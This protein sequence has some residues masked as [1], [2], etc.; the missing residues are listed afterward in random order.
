MAS[1][2]GSGKSHPA[3]SVSSYYRP[4]PY[5]YQN[6]YYLP[7]RSAWSR[8]PPP[9][10]KKSNENK[11]WKIGSAVLVVSGLI[12]LV[13]VLAI[14]GLALWMGAMRSDIK[15]SSIGFS[16]SL[17]IAR[18][19]KYNP[20]LKLNTSMVFREMERKYKNIFELLFRRSVLGSCFKQT[21]IDR[22]ENGTLKV[23]F[24]LYLDRRKIPRSITN[25]EDTIQ[26][27]I[28]KETYSTTSLFKDMELD[29]TSISIRRINAESST[30]R[31]QK[32][33]I[34]QQRNTMI[35]KNGLLRPNKTS[36]LL[37]TQIQKSK[38]SKI[39]PNEADIDFTN[40]PTIQGSYQ[41]TKL[42]LTNDAQKNNIKINTNRNFT[43]TT[44][45]TTTARSNLSINET[46][47]KDNNKS[48]DDKIE[49][50]TASTTILP[51]KKISTS[52]T[53][54][55]TTTIKRNDEFEKFSH[56]SFEESPWRPII[57]NYSHTE[58]IFS[59]QNST[60][61]SSIVSQTNLPENI[62]QKN[63]GNFEYGI[64]ETTEKINDDKILSTTNLSLDDDL[65]FNYATISIE[66]DFPHDRIVPEEMINFRPNGKFKNKIPSIDDAS[67]FDIDRHPDIEISGHLPEETFD[68][69]LKTFPG[70]SKTPETPKNA[71]ND[72][73]KRDKPVE[74]TQTVLDEIKNKNIDA[75]DE[76][77]MSKIFDKPEEL[78][79]SG[80][81]I[82]E[83]VLEHEIDIESRN[84]FSDI[85]AI[86][87][88]DEKIKNDKNI[89]QQIVS[90]FYTS[91]RTPE[92]NGFIKPS[93]ID[94]PGTLKPFKHTIPVDKISSNTDPLSLI[95]H[96][97]EQAVTKN[98]GDIIENKDDLILPDFHDKTFDTKENHD[99]KKII[100]TAMNPLDLKLHESSTEN[101]NNLTLI[102]DNG[103]SSKPINN[104]SAIESTSP[105]INST[106]VEVVTV[107]H[108]P[109]LFED[110]SSMWK[111]G[112]ESTT[113]A[114]IKT[115]ND[116]LKAN[117]VKSIVTLAPTKSNSGVNRPIRP[118]PV[119]ENDKVTR[120]LIG[121]TKTNDNHHLI[122]GGT[123]LQS[124]FGS[125]DLVKP[126]LNQQNHHHDDDNKNIKSIVEVVTSISTKVSTKTKSNSNILS[127]YNVTNSTS[128]PQVDFQHTKLINDENLQQENTKQL[129]NFEQINP[130]VNN[131]QL[132]YEKLKKFA[133]IR[134]DN[135][136]SLP[137]NKN[138]TK[139]IPLK[140]ENDDD[141]R[142]INI[143]FDKI[144]E[145][146]NV[147]TGNKTIKAFNDNENSSLSRD[148][149]EI[150][151]KTLH[152]VD[153][154]KTTTK[155]IPTTTTT[156]ATECLTGFLCN[157]GKCLPATGR[158]NMLG[159]CLNSEDEA[160]CTCADFLKTQLLVHKICDGILDCWDYSDEENCDWCTK[161]QFVCGNSQ[162]CVDQGKVCDGTWDCP[163]GEDE[164]KCAALIEDDKNHDNKTFDNLNDRI[165]NK[166]YDGKN[167][168]SKIDDNLNKKIINTN[169]KL[170]F[171]T[172]TTLKI[173]SDDVDE[174]DNS[175]M[176]YLDKNVKV[177]GRE[178]S[179]S[180]KNKLMGSNSF[181]AS[182]KVGHIIENN[183]KHVKEV[184]GYS[185][186]GFLSVRKNGKW[187]KLCLNGME[188]LM[189]ERRALWTIEDLGRAVCKAI[190]YQ[191][192]ENVEKITDD[193]HD[194]NKIYY[195]LFFNDKTTDKTSLTF[196]LSTCP[197]REVLRVKC[198]NLECGIRTQT[199]SQARIVGGD[200]STAGSWPWQ[201]AL[202]KE[203]DY[204]CGG[205]LINNKWILSAAH[206]F[207]RTQNEYWVA[208]IG[209][210][211]R[212][213][214][215][216]PHEQIITLDYVALHPD[217]IDNGF[218]NDVALL[219]LEKS[220][221]FSDYVRPICLPDAEPK[222][223]TKCTVTGWGQLFEVGRIFPDTLQEVELPLISTEEC[224]R[225]T[226]FLPLYRITAGMLCAGLKDG[227]RDACMG[228]SGG[229]LVCRGPD[230][231]YTLHGITS[232]G[233]G[234]A[235]PGRPGVYTKVHH[236][237]SWIDKTMLDTDVPSIVPV[238]KGHRCPLGEC[239]PKSRVCNG[240]LEC[241]DGSDERNCMPNL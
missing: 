50:S 193:R 204:Q 119:I 151:T 25:V 220:V 84:K 235:R 60:T 126:L 108:K 182:S 219:R 8:V 121:N 191:D 215:P 154:I 206:C 137:E 33:N 113:E 43:T 56:P 9:S 241:S 199:T 231:R 87:N 136:S 180:T 184:N 141:D 79:I 49:T 201:V 173:I 146:A 129:R 142:K 169:D 233:Y 62:N 205:A 195:S 149:I 40:I 55:S 221:V 122:E 200:S 133:E 222:S 102:I 81:G 95:N 17:R 212:G 92:L 167:I 72:Y 41:A 131:E 73:G 114:G 177:V 93:I 11:T 153:D 185:D 159:E 178:I 26:D 10:S 152:K 197:S 53:V 132:L 35:T 27:I 88:I 30:A 145:W 187:G 83:P 96:Q 59:L 208:R 4:S 68:I 140:Y 216:S 46:M 80:I 218:I 203:G 71:T 70:L 100:E 202:Y 198:K 123:L 22:F 196:K 174:D 74:S 110:E 213:S 157:D 224:T 16:C 39:E 143:Q 112:N 138:S 118:R 3:L 186:R 158:C 188:N 5:P 209:A 106:F 156:A 14:A 57:P 111:I 2:C 210:T 101:P 134:R 82:A 223:G 162:F 77:E 78:K 48:V 163:S 238:C 116:T 36:P 42:N 24:R 168:W 214:F 176:D 207:Y 67:K 240:F 85:L 65:K 69:H 117:I 19:E 226:L 139:F 13:V 98:T 160:N 229:P 15:N 58:S 230:N 234:C 127:S 148:G 120:D 51:V 189:E 107:E 150:L 236:Y 28:A 52:S 232:N 190:T 66:T 175:K 103:N 6:D 155:K 164:K 86:D 194:D 64:I 239:L 211:R 147:S 227:G 47:F 171:E 29:L 75:I 21:L 18:G 32:P 161:G 45:T 91:Y 34:S 166:R 105:L 128:K 20:M 237:I 225:K 181:H 1:V 217:Y 109:V 37:S 12:V 172:T 54:P 170:L 97:N 144:K 99:T 228:D 179:S 94:N 90:P 63:K 61:V 104:F 183:N 165:N 38:P 130:G 7:H 192:Y 124:I 115:Y 31:T 23:F 89:Q 135:E 125:R 76:I 44:T